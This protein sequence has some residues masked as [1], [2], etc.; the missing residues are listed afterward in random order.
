[1][2]ALR[3]STRDHV[4]WVQKIPVAY[5]TVAR[6][7]IVN[8]EDAVL[9]ATHLHPWV[10]QGFHVLDFSIGQV[11]GY[12]REH[13]ASR[14]FWL[15]AIFASRI[16]RSG[17]TQ[18]CYVGD[19]GVTPRR[20]QLWRDLTLAL[21]RV[22]KAALLT[23]AAGWGVNR[24]AVIQRCRVVVYCRSYADAPAISRGRTDMIWNM[25]ID[26]ISEL[27]LSEDMAEYQGTVEFYP[28]E[29]IPAAVVRYLI[30]TRS[31]VEEENLFR[32]RFA[33]EENRRAVF[34]QTVQEFSSVA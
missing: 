12:W 25:G 13:N 33:V 5:P 26:L 10:N 4:I 16:Q 31:A 18:V 28:F 23:V 19:P 7:W 2:L 9:R 3:L 20:N 6:R 21:Q 34:T 27:S 30:R 14:A 22:N 24:D 29:Q 15:P 1:M 8:T 17:G 11:N 32:R